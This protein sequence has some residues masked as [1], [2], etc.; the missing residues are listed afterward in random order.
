MCLLMTFFVCKVSREAM[1]KFCQKTYFI[2]EGAIYLEML[3]QQLVEF[4]AAV[5]HKSL[6]VWS[7]LMDHQRAERVAYRNGIWASR[8]WA[9]LRLKIE[10]PFCCCSVQKQ[11]FS[12]D[13][14]QQ[15][16]IT[17][18]LFSRQSR[19]SNG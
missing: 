8:V 2:Q 11:K 3:I 1:A 10:D 15:N 12:S 19:M 16:S 4:P 9:N 18:K 17:T 6:S 7:R 14:D 5:T 13:V